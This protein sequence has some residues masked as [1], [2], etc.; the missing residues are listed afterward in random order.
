VGCVEAEKVT[1]CAYGL[2]LSIW[3]GRKMFTLTPTRKHEIGR[4]RIRWRIMYIE[5]TL[6]GGEGICMK[7]LMRKPKG[8]GPHGKVAEMGRCQNHLK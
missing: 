4:P 2:R 5:R 1:H 6:N 3:H 7:N 8:K